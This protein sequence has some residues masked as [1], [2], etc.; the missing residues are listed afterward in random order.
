VVK[1]T[2]TT[3]YFVRAEGPCD[4][5]SCATVKVNVTHT[6]SAPVSITSNYTDVCPG[7]IVRLK[8][9]GPAKLP[10]EQYKWYIDNGGSLTPVGQGDSIAINISKVRECLL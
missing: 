2:D 3:Q 4:V 7:T 5:S 8:A 9:Q 10:G 6:P 1:P